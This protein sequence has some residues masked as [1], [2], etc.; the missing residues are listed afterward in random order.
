MGQGRGSGLDGGQVATH[1]DFTG[2]KGGQQSLL[3]GG[4]CFLRVVM[5]TAGGL[6]EP[7]GSPA[8]MPPPDPVLVTFLISV[9]CDT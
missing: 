3:A 2:S 4:M 1:R 7:H 9:M 5:C 8:R 6:R